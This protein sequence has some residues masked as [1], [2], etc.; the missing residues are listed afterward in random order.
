[1][2]K[3]QILIVLLLIGA[4][5]AL[6]FLTGGPGDGVGN[7]SKPSLEIAETP[8][9]APYQGELLAH[10]FES[11]TKMPTDIH[12]KDRAKAQEEVVRACLEIGQPELAR[13]YAEKIENWRRGTAYAALAYFW[14]VR[15]K[16]E[17]ASRYLDLA[18]D[19]AENRAR[20]P[21][22]QEWRI[23]RIRVQSAQARVLLGQ[24][25]EAA[26]L[27]KGV[28]KSEQGKVDSERARV[29]DAGIIKKQLAVVDGAFASGDFDIIR[30]A[31]PTAVQLVRRFY[32]DLERRSD[33]ETRIR[34][35][36]EKVPAQVR[37]HAF[38]ELAQA[39]LEEKDTAG[40][41]TYVEK[42]RKVLDA[43]TWSP[44]FQVPLT[45][46]IAAARVKA[47]QPDRGR[48][49]VEE[50]EKLFQANRER[51]VNFERADCLRPIAEV[52]V[53]LGDQKNARRVYGT[54]I[55]EGAVNPNARPRAQDLAKTLCS[56]AVERFEPEPALKTRIAEIVAGLDHPW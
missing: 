7:L 51:I 9:F 25:Q 39:A 14:A 8:P 6:F 45:A 26:G 32:S 49:E 30:N 1:M 38:L 2:S 27:E 12:P 3:P 31:I 11:V 17:E 18:H 22:Q 29:G 56:M 33:L 50:A 34:K 36:I 15:K 40:S 54:A 41:A 5:V 13:R 35:A 19:V 48:S 23:H 52:F 21:H 42:A 16:T 20:V 24:F 53:A 28:V 44:E 10:A 37:I 55:D 4:G 46:T 43:T 47:G